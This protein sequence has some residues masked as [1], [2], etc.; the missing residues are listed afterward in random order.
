MAKKYCVVAVQDK[1]HKQLKDAEK[2]TGLPISRM[3]Q[4]ALQAY[5]DTDLTALIAFH[6]SKKRR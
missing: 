2:I 1:Q 5:I 6:E 3:V 4:E